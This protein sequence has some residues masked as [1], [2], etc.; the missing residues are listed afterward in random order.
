MR[1][2][3][4]HIGANRFR[5]LTGR[6]L[7]REQTFHVLAEDPRLAAAAFEV[8]CGHYRTDKRFRF[9][10]ELH[11]ITPWLNLYSVM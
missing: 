6:E 7:E 5:E 9:T 11:D 8:N 3:V 10:Q 1:K 2:R 4:Q